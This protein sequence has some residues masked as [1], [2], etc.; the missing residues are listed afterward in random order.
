ML[1][2]NNQHPNRGEKISKVRREK[3]QI[4]ASHPFMYKIILHITL[5]IGAILDESTI[6]SSRGKS[7]PKTPMKV[8][9]SMLILS[10]NLLLYIFNQIS[11][12]SALCTWPNPEHSSQRMEN[13]GN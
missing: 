11:L 7:S 10:S 12:A 1:S 8:C 3:S 4:R 2:A 13:F 9:L 5:G 6:I